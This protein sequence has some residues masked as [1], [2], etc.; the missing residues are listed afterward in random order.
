MSK[1]THSDHDKVVTGLLD[2]PCV[3]IRE[4]QAITA[5]LEERENL[6]RNLQAADRE[7]D[8]WRHGV[9]VEG[10]YVCPDSLRA[11][12]VADKYRSAMEELRFE[13]MTLALQAEGTTLRSDEQDAGVATYE[14][15]RGKSKAFRQ[16]LDVIDAA[17]E[18]KP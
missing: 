15:Y 16:V 2:K 7:A 8:R 10:D 5:L 9:P 3:S 17:M 1:I 13:V 4:G 11:D 12:L 6:R 14:F 18:T